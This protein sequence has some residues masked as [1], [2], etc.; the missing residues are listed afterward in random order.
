MADRQAQ[1]GSA[2]VWVRVVEK[3][4]LTKA[5]WQKLVTSADQ[6]ACLAFLQTTAYR[7]WLQDVDYAKWAQ[8]L[9]IALADTYQQIQKHL[10]DPRLYEYL[11]LRGT[12]HALKQVMLAEL[13]VHAAPATVATYL[14]FSQ[15]DLQAAVTDPKAANLPEA[16]QESITQA[17]EADQT[18]GDLTTVMMTLD[19]RYF[20]HLNILAQQLADQ[21]LQQY[22][23]QVI[24][25]HNLMTFLRARR[26]R[27]PRSFLNA[28]LA[29][30]GNVRKAQWLAQYH[31]DFAE[32]IDFLATTTLSPLNSAFSRS[33]DQESISLAPITR[34]IDR[35]E[36][37]TLQAAQLEALG[38]LPIVAYW[39]AKTKEVQQLKLLNLAKQ[40]GWTSAETK[41]RL[42]LND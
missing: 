31:S 36:Q 8:Q 32:L 5:N 30:G 25:H 22:T 2:N 35:R 4:L 37:A 17:H 24:D 29:D 10:P 1:Y 33:D 16:Y 12:Y 19:Q 20:S 34:A 42:G 18:Y 40:Q 7:P 15:S 38:P 26:Q 39:Q 11:C 3:K 9:P 28:V 13:A 41:V 14:P 23:R 6:A 27:Q 21:T